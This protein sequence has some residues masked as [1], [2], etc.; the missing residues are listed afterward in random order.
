MITMAEIAGYKVG[1]QSFLRSESM[2]QAYNR[3]WAAMKLTG[4][5]IVVI[6]RVL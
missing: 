1:P 3:A 2:G 4:K 6:E 5:P